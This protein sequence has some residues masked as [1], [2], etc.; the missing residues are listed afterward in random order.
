MVIY[1]IIFKQILFLIILMLSITC[2]TGC[3]SFP[4][5]DFVSKTP[6]DNTVSISIVPLCS[7]VGDEEMSELLNEYEK[8]VIESF[9]SSNQ[10]ST[11]QDD[12]DFELKISARICDNLCPECVRPSIVSV[13]Q[14]CDNKTN[15][16]IFR[17][18]IMHSTVSRGNCVH[19][20]FPCWD[21]LKASIKTAMAQLEAY[22]T[23]RQFQNTS[24]LL[25]VSASSIDSRKESWHRVEER[26][27]I[28][29]TKTK[30]EFEIASALNIGNERIFVF[31]LEPGNYILSGFTKT[32]YYGT[33]Y[34]IQS[35][36]VDQLF[37]IPESG[38]IYCLDREMKNIVKNLSPNEEVYVI[39]TTNNTESEQ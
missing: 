8:N 39:N 10:F 21:N 12:A 19:P 30:K 31:G 32:T 2:I 34:T 4:V 11:V 22:A 27:N 7:D 9:D 38:K 35:S 14:L 36:H 20:F 18:Y 29:N 16:E 37:T 1:K 28:M 6:F 13:W 3:V 25:F 26:A 15:N 23:E 17:S 33:G 5:K 24:S